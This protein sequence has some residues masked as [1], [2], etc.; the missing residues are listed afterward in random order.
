MLPGLS[1]EYFLAVSDQPGVPLNAEAP[2]YSLISNVKTW[3]WQG[4]LISSCKEL[5]P[6]CR[7]TEHP[8][9]SVRPREPYAC[10][11]VSDEDADGGQAIVQGLHRFGPFPACF[12]CGSVGKGLEIQEEIEYL[13][14]QPLFY[15]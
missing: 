6:P 12:I 15:F 4:G 5:G 14:S 8:D 1:H 7:V 13:H 10:D 11:D 2:V 3:S 9:G